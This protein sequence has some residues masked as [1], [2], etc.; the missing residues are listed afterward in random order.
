MLSKKAICNYYLFLV[1]ILIAQ[2]FFTILS[3]NHDIQQRQRVVQLEDQQRQLEKEITHLETEISLNYS[4]Q[5]NFNEEQAAEYIDISRDNI[6]TASL[7]MSE[8]STNLIAQQF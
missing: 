3:G 6:T 5:A 4:V 7:P 2:A 1:L 8:A